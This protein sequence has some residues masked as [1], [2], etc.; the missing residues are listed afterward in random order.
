M[1]KKTAKS[2]VKSTKSTTKLA[3]KP[4]QGGWDGASA[5]LPTPEAVAAAYAPVKARPRRA[6]HKVAAKVQR[7]AVKKAALK[8]AV[9]QQVKPLSKAARAKESE[10]TH[11]II[12]RAAKKAGAAGLPKIVESAAQVEKAIALAAYWP[13]YDE[14]RSMSEGWLL[15]ATN[16]RLEIQRYDAHTRFA[17]DVYAHQ[18]VVRKALKGSVYHVA[19]LTLVTQ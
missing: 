10:E 8:A 15:A 16:D 12:A 1:K 18:F 6:G 13:A 7:L 11:E 2:T 3:A 5:A 14:K 19:M 9:A 4:I 17:S